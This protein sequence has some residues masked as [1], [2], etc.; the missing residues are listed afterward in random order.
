MTSPTPTAPTRTRQNVALGAAL[1]L[2]N[3]VAFSGQTAWA[4]E[5]LPTW[6]PHGLP[7]GAVAFAASLEVLAIYLALEA[8]AA[9][10][11]GDSAAKLKAASYAVG[12]TVG[13][14]NYAHWAGP[15]MAPN[16]GALAYGGLSAISPFLW[17]IRSR[18]VNRDELRAKDLIEPRAVKFSTARWVLHFDRTFRAFRLAVWA[19][20]TNPH[21]AI[22][23]L[24][25]PAVAPT[26]VG[27]SAP[28]SKPQARDYES[29]A[30][31]PETLPV[32][33]VAAKPAA[34]GLKAAPSRE[35]ARAILMALP[36]FKAV[37]NGELA[38]LH[39]GSDR[40]WAGAKDRLHA[41]LAELTAEA[42]A[43]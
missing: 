1:V 17:A 7:I 16:A 31:T 14:L 11:A 4:A 39:S 9:L 35:Q 22:A 23:L 24:G 40:F 32:K 42:K 10:M 3:T 20:E 19:G 15:G 29:P 13:A 41:E 28:D 43:L 21:A 26:G 12:L 36:D 2:V 34:K 18:S 30:P 27:V 6:T 5:H 8:H 37:T 25:Q 38:R 33:A